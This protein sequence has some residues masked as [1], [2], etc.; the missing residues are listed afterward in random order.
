[1]STKRRS[2]VAGLLLVLSGSQAAGQKGLTLTIGRLSFSESQIHQV[3]SVKNESGNTV[4]SIKIECGFFWENQLVAAGHAYIEN[5]VS[6]SAGFA[7]VTARS[8]TGS[9]R[10]QCRISEIR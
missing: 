6:G 3:V 1:M 10:S 9:D 7:D 4:S 8:D 5:V 2:A